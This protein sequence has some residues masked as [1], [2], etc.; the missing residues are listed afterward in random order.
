MKKRLGACFLTILLV[1][2]A[3]WRIRIFLLVRETSGRPPPCFENLRVIDWAKTC[4]VLDHRWQDGTDCDNASNRAVISA[5]FQQYSTDSSGR[6]SVGPFAS[7][8]GNVPICPDGGT[9][10]FNPLGKP[11]ECSF[12]RQHP[13][14]AEKHSLE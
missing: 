9:Y 11:P 3:L 5:Y 8:Q 13:S 10:R 6:K 1:V 12:A 7:F 2:I 14:T 4:A